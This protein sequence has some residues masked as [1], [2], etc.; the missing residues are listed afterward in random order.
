MTTAVPA[1]GLRSPI[2]LSN[3][4]LR[5]TYEDRDDAVDKVTV[6]LANPDLVLL[7]RHDVLGGAVW[8]VS[9]GIGGAMMRARAM[10]VRSVRG[11]EVLTVEGHARHI[12]MDHVVRS[13]TFHGQ[14]R[15]QVMSR[16]AAEHGFQGP[17]AQ[18]ADT[19]ERFET[20]HQV[21][22]TDARFL[23][24]L[25]RLED[26]L[27]SLDDERLVIGP[28]TSLLEPARVFHWRPGRSDGDVKALNVESNLALVVSKVVLRGR[29]PKEK[30]TITATATR[31]PDEQRG[32]DGFFDRISGETGRTRVEERA[33]PPG[34]TALTQ[35]TTVT[36]PA[37]AQ[38]KAEAR[39]RRLDA[40]AV[41]VTLQ[42]VGDA[43]L[44]TKQVVE[45]RGA[46]RR[47]SGRYVVRAVKHQISAEGYTVEL[48]AR[49]LV[50]G[51]GASVQPVGA[52]PPA[53]SATAQTPPA[54][55]PPTPVDLIDPET[56]RTRAGT[57]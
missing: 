4:V 22:E 33:A 12:S 26:F 8:Q 35:P 34:T 46:S 32:L 45:L 41:K 7:D 16:V 42:V 21:A 24:R 3:R 39:L 17:F 44:R 38:R 9:W 1:L 48:T 6:Q 54:A 50:G 51:E 30:K 25:A 28:A 18:I 31:T 43:T 23:R 20:I 2:D 14:T 37:G 19:D 11:V 52:P 47:L 53:T 36:S 5:F 27:F 15:S 40:D 29:D 10:A 49:R 13:R 56:G 57:Q 55:R